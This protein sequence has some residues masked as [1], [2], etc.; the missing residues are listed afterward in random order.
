ME[1]SPIQDTPQEREQ[2]LGRDRA[3]L[4]FSIDS[5]ETDIG[6]PKS[7]FGMSLEDMSKAIY[8]FITYV[9]H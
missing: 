2:D 3:S 7:R 9:L 8:K 5:G 1:E 6:E 4:D